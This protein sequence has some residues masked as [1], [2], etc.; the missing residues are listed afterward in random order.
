[1]KNA[2]KRIAHFLDTRPLGVFALAFGVR[3]M[4]LGFGLLLVLSGLSQ[5]VLFENLNELGGAQVYGAIL[6]VVS[7]VTMTAAALRHR[8]TARVALAI[9]AWFWLFACMSYLFN[10]NP[11]MAS[12]FMVMCCIPS[13]YLAYFS[14]HAVVDTTAQQGL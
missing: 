1:M 12:L 4:L 7:V 14:K 8:V 5:S 9:Q 10:G 6:V 13:G 3:D 2:V 11:L